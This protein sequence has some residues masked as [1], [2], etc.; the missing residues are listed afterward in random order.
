MSRVTMSMK[1]GLPFPQREQMKPNQT[2][3]DADDEKDRYSQHVGLLCKRLPA[4]A[5]CTVAAS[6]Y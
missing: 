2:K 6:P 4:L 5:H 3:Y 1:H